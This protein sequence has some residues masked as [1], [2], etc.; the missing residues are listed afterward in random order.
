VRLASR[1][2]PALAGVQRR[3]LVTTLRLVVSNVL[4]ALGT[5]VLSAS[6]SLAGR[7][8]EEQAFTVTLSVGVVILFV[9]FMVPSVRTSD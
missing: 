8:G 6:G 3:N 4:I 9:G 1:R 7:L 2:S 5:L